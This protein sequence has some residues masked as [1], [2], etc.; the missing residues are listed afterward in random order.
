MCNSQL[1]EYDLHKLTRL[2]LF[3]PEKKNQTDLDYS[4]KYIQE[5]TLKRFFILKDKGMRTPMF[6]DHI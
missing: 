2:S 4:M 5:A 3:N 6:T 1:E